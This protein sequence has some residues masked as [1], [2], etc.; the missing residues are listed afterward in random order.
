MELRAL[1][2]GR[3]SRHDAEQEGPVQGR[4]FTLEMIL[5]TVRWYLQFAISCC[6]VALGS[7]EKLG[8][9]AARVLSALA[10][11]HHQLDGAS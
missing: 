1:G 5:W 4:K 11:A 7:V 8:V 3:R 2:S 10:P 6:D 9:P